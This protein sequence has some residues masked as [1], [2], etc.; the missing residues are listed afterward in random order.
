MEGGIA[1]L[2]VDESM[3]VLPCPVDARSSTKPS[4][5][6]PP[7]GPRFRPFVLLRLL[8]HALVPSTRPR[9]LKKIAQKRLC[10]TEAKVDDHAED[11]LCF[12]HH[13]IA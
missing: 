4:S 2:K 6:P 1:P 13:E 12:D 3:M 5:K 9:P 11:L 7:I 10:G 8:L